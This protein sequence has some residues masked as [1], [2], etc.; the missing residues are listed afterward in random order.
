MT[1]DLDK[2]RQDLLIYKAV[3]ERSYD[4]IARKTNLHK[5][6]VQ[7]FCSGTRPNI[8]DRTA[9]ILQNFLNAYNGKEK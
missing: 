5:T 6:T 8:N 7:K 3:E 4:Y 2:L 1:I 9:I